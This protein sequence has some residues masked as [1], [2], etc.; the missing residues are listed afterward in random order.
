ME[1][2]F[3]TETL[4]IEMKRYEKWFVEN[5]TETKV[6]V[7]KEKPKYARRDEIFRLNRDVSANTYSLEQQLVAYQ[8]QSMQ[9]HIFSE[10]LL[11]QSSLC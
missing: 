4:S 3:E 10:M 8:S 7:L 5:K 2:V 11:A 6:G 1:P 9:F